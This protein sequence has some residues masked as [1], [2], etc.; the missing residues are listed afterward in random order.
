[1]SAGAPRRPTTLLHV[2]AHGSDECVVFFVCVYSSEFVCA[3]V[4]S[5]AL[6][7]RSTSDDGY[8]A[9]AHECVIKLCALLCVVCVCMCVC[10]YGGVVE[11]A[12]AHTHSLM[13]LHYDAWIIVSGG[14]CS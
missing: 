6:Q 4:C 5:S 9:S 7:E 13:D 8:E 3:C 2:R 1:M 11:R 10:M 12:R 14:P